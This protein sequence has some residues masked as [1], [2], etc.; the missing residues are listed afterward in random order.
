MKYK[1]L[2]HVESK[3]WN[4]NLSACEYS[5]F[6]QTAEFL[7][8]KDSDRYPVFI[9]IYDNS[10]NIQGQLGLV[11]SR[12]RSGYTTKIF[13]KF[14]KMA[15]KV[16]SRGSW[17]SGPI[18]HSKDKDV[19]MQ[20]LQTLFL[21]L[22]EVIQKHK[23]IILDGYTP[24]QDFDVDQTYLTEFQKH[25]FKQQN[26]LTLM[27]NLDEDSETFWK[28]IKK[29]A[30]NDVTK[31]KREGIIIKEISTMEELTNYK[32][33]T[34]RWAQ[35]KGIEITDSDIEKID[36]DWL[37]LKSGIQKFFLAYNKQEILAGLRIGY[38]NKIAYTH[39]VL[40]SYSKIGNVAGPLLTWHAIN[41][42]KDNGM[43]IYDFSGGEAPPSDNKDMK[44]YTE[45]WE[46]LFAYKRKWS[47]DEFPYYH[48]IKI[49]NKERYKLYR[50]LSKPDMFLRNYN[51]KHFKKSNKGVTE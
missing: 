18:I 20:V 21:A 5:T 4:N 2:S 42:A 35:T 32:L 19:R 49:I 36:T 1:I 46:S 9:Y 3:E 48:F 22:E 30:R 50:I 37:Y 14:T 16:G 26:F 23:L 17:T 25:G 7:S 10:E 13:K 38:F 11:I 33:L 40:N 41:W 27:S 34:K 12:S 31:A 8:K 47:G 28:K 51:K 44:R 24:P 43:R 6:F 45:Q 29:S 15:S 39:Q